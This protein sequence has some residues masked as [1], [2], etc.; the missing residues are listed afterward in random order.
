[1]Q[2]KG[3]EILTAPDNTY[4]LAMELQSLTYDMVMLENTRASAFTVR[5]GI[6]GHL[7]D[8]VYAGGPNV[9]RMTAT[10]EA[11]KQLEDRC[12]VA[13]MVMSK[14]EQ[15]IVWEL[16]GRTADVP[17][18][19]ECP[20]C[21]G[22]AKLY[23]GSDASSS[24]TMS[25]VACTR[26]EKVSGPFSQGIE[27]HGM[28]NPWR[29]SHISIHG[30]V[31]E[32]EIEAVGEWNRR[33]VGGKAVSFGFR[34]G[35]ASENW[36]DGREVAEGREARPCP[37]CGGDPEMIVGMG[38]CE[39]VWDAQMVCKDC[40]LT[41]P[42]TYGLDS[43]SPD[44]SALKRIRAEYPDMTIHD[45]RKSAYLACLSAWNHRAHGREALR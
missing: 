7:M 9:Q 45:C 36:A 38:Y 24:T 18:I 44:P 25:Y 3:V 30:T 32:A 4:R 28:R 29:N 35:P 34:E 15:E 43:V 20:F 10:V 16:S 6:E 14:R 13:V 23:N 33:T 42:R 39:D 5:H 8:G 40:I 22:E 31:R 21:G 1:M 2:Q 27:F 12:E 11:L 26:C 37:L 19:S 17:A 41:G